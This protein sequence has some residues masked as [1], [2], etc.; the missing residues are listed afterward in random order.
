MLEYRGYVGSV[1]FDDAAD[2]FHGEVVGL[3]DV[4]TFQGTTPQEI[5]QAFQESIDDY[6][7]FCKAR[8]EKPKK[9]YSGKFVLRT[10]L[11]K[12]I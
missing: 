7:D 10:S 4:I 9:P 5:K 2:L 12:V 1:I 6:L 11:E 8:G 3:R